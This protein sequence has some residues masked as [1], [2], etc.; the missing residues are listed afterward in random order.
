MGLSNCRFSDF[1]EGRLGSCRQE[2]DL[3]LASSV[4]VILGLYWGDIGIME[5]KMGAAIMGLHRV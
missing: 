1:Q 5:R 3:I 4:A 2:K